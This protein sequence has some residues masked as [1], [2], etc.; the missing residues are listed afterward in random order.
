MTWLFPPEA[1]MVKMDKLAGL[2]LDGE[3]IIK[4]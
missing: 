1:R 3:G 4:K 2:K